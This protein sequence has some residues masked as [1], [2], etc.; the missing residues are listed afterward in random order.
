[1][2]VAWVTPYPPDRNGG[3]GHI[4]EAHLLAA[5]AQRASITVITGG[6]V[7]DPAV[8]AAAERIVE[9]GPSTPNWLERGRLA[10]RAGDLW[11]ATMARTAREARA[12]RSLRAAMVPP[13]AATDAEVVLIEYTGLTP[14]IDE[15]GLAGLRARSRWVVTAVNLPS[16]MA[17]H[18]AAI[19]PKRRQRWLFRREAALARRFEARLLHRYDQVITVSEEDRASLA[20][21]AGVEVVANGVDLA[22]FSPSPLPTGH[23]LVYTGALY[24][25]PNTDAAVW[26]ARHILPRVRGEI[27]DAEVDL[28]GLAP[29]PAVRELGRLPGVRVHADVDD[30]RPFLRGARVAVIPVRIGSGTRL[31]ALEAWASGRPVVGTTLGLEGLGAVD[32]EHALVA[33]DPAAFATAVV[34]VLSDT[35]LAQGLAG[36]GRALAASHHGW[37]EAARRFVAVIDPDKGPA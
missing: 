8:V 32:G 28:V 3:G 27:P 12:L 11:G 20:A 4:R 15:P 14:L 9:V 35:D 18:Q 25:T 10:R 36:R 5:L 1:M 29:P 21:P 26:L 2:R 16:R 13:L 31:K 34:R 19:M 23:R 37:T 6:Q 30:V 22:R 7:T 17:D 33:D 24:T